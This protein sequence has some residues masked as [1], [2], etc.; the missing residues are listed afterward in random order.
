MPREKVFRG[1]RIRLWREQRGLAQNE[2]A[3]RMDMNIPQLS[4][5]ETGRSDPSLEI[6]VRLAK[7][8]DVTT[9]YLLGLVDE[10][11]AH[12]QPPDLTAAER[13]LVAAFRRKDWRGILRLLAEQ[14]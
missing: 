14:L 9:D 4:R 1:D 12:Y 10:A 2:F 7:E 6:L 8:L 3:Q 11:D 13:E 5:Y